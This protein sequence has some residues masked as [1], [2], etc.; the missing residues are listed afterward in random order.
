MKN[1]LYPIFLSHYCLIFS[2]PYSKTPLTCLC[3]Y[4]HV[5]CSYSPV[6]L[7]HR[8][9]TSHTPLKQL[10]TLESLLDFLELSWQSHPMYS[11][12]D[13]YSPRCPELHFQPR[14]F[15]TNSG[16][17]YPAFY[18]I[19]FE[20]LKGILKLTSSNFGLRFPTPAQT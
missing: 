10:S 17:M 16:L 13:D 15:P 18:L 20:H 7:S 5:P 1:S 6:L 11:S 9:L 3:F 12:S 19:P 8:F 14:S 2:L 4:L